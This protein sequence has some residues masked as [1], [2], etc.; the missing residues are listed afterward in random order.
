MTNVKK[1]P[2]K[3]PKCK[4]PRHSRDWTSPVTTILERYIEVC[5]YPPV[6]C[7]RLDGFENSQLRFSPYWNIEYKVDCEKAFASALRNHPHLVR[8]L[9]NI[10]KEMAEQDFEPVSAGER[11]ATI[12]LLGPVLQ[13][14]GLS[15]W[16]Y[17]SRVRQ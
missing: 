10:L 2:N 9:Q 4:Q 11:V 5:A 1:R 8:V 13:R 12:Q 15:P 16:S 14:F 7:V 3:R 6:G 17:F